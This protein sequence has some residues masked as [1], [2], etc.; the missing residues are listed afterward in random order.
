[1]LLINSF[2]KGTFLK[3]VA[4]TLVMVIVEMRINLLFSNGSFLLIY[5]PPNKQVG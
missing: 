4:A 2:K 5:L 3:D 1:M